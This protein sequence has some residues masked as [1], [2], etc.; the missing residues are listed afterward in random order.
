MIGGAAGAEY[1]LAKAEDLRSETPLEED[2]FIQALEWGVNNG[3]HR[4][5]AHTHTHTQT[6]AHA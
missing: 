1:L 5:H 3:A 6:R 2:L 4:N